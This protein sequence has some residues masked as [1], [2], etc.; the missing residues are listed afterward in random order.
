MWGGT[1]A[2]RLAFVTP[3]L[4]RAPGVPRTGITHMQRS[5]GD[6]RKCATTGASKGAS[7]FTCGSDEYVLRVEAPGFAPFI[8][9]TLDLGACRQVRVPVRL[10]VAALHEEISVLDDQSQGAHAGSSAGALVL[11]GRQLDLLSNDRLTLQQQLS[12]LEWQAQSV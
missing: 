12:G 3:Q 4:K 5:R 8:N 7:S 1:G 10:L 11:E 6:S 2:R 9:R